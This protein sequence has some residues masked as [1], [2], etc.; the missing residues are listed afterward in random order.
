MVSFGYGHGEVPEADATWDVRRRFRNPADDPALKLMTG[1][2]QPVID[3]VLATPGVRAFVDIVVWPAVRSMLLKMEQP[4]AV[5]VGCAGGRHRSVVIADAL[6]VRAESAAWSVEVEHRHV[7]RPVLEPGA[8][9]GAGYMVATGGGDVVVP[10]AFRASREDAVAE[11]T[12]RRR[13][14]PTAALFALHR[15]A[16]E[17]RG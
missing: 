16:G 17:S 14:Y 10:L 8:G 4:I 5:A 13:K 11:W 15:V 1:R 12:G 7:D 2:D 3:H 6:A 9:S